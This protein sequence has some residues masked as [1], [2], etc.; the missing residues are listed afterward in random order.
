[1]QLYLDDLPDERGKILDGFTPEQ[2]FWFGLVQK[3]RMVAKPTT[4]EYMAQNNSHPPMPP[5]VNGIVTNLEEWHRDF[6]VGPEH[7]RYRPPE[8]RV[9]I[10]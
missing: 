2:R 3:T 1:M 4:L 5:G 10:W 6:A 8:K 7:K 9:R